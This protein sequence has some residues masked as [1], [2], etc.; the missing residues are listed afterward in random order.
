M[1]KERNRVVVIGLGY[2]GLTLAAHMARSGFKVHGVEIREE[3]LE[4][5]TKGKAFFLEQGLDSLLEKVIAEGSFTFSKDIPFSEESR[6][7]II[8]VGTPLKEDGT[9]NIDFIT[10]VSESV[11]NHLREDDFVILRSTVKLGTTNN[12]VKP[13]LMQKQKTFGLAFC[14]ER[15]LEGAAL[16]ELGLL[17]QIIGTSDETAR[18]IANSIFVK[19]TSSVVHVS[20][21]ET[22]ELIKLTDNM[23]RDVHFAISN[24][25]AKI[26]NIFEINASEVIAAG[27][28]GYPRTNLAM[29]G[30]VGGPCLEKD[31]YLL[32]ESVGWTSSLSLAARKTNESIIQD[33]ID[34]LTS[35]LVDF[36]NIDKTDQH[37]GIGFL[38]LAFKGV[39]ETDDLRGSLGV[40]LLNELYGVYKNASISF[41]DSL[42]PKFESSL[43]P[44]AK[45]N[46]IIDVF[47]RSHLVIITNN[48]PNFANL[49]LDSLSAKM[50]P[51]SIIY[52]LWGRY[53]TIIDSHKN[54]RCSWGSLGK[55]R[56]ISK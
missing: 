48:H 20:S 11:A 10:R 3:V 39:P 44:I 40:T 30:P 7:F 47:S 1:I 13:I 31:T 49:D 2:V 54:L 19:L 14:P 26:G 45:C 22:A 52:D 50:P 32:N 28:L 35:V 37:I 24:E 56:V 21:I 41:Y 25:V 29:P 34:F 5:L 51:K 16:T 38:G 33:S 9:V 46:E 12:I 55:A 36:S 6:I 18:S 27:K 17:P 23:Q 42:I 43:G 4:P 8:T 53:E 15:T